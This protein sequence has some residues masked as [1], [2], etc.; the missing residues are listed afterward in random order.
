MAAYWLSP[1]RCYTTLRDVALALAASAP[2][3]YPA[4]SARA[5]NESMLLAAERVLFGEDHAVAGARMLLSWGMPESI[6]AIVAGH[7]RLGVAETDSALAHARKII[8]AA[9]YTDGLVRNFAIQSAGTIEPH[10]A[11]QL[12]KRVAWYRSAMHGA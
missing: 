7:H 8:H 6:V 10:A 12:H 5:Q 3:A 2:L 9:G 1:L 11:T 4:I